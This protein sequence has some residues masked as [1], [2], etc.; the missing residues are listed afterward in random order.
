MT[1][2]NWDLPGDGSRRAP[3]GGPDAVADALALDRAKW[4]V[5]FAELPWYDADAQ[6]WPAEIEMANGPNIVVHDRA[7]YEGIRAAMDQNARL[8]ARNE[9]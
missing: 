2:R 4:P 3:S 1:V 9:P 6:D 5:E 7:Q 8:D